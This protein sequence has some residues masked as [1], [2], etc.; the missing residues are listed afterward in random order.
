LLT[1]GTECLTGLWAEI[2]ALP[3][4]ASAAGGTDRRPGARRNLGV[5][6]G[7][8]GILY[9]SLRWC[10]A[11]GIALPESLP[12]LL[13]ELAGRAQPWGRGL[14]WR[15]VRGGDGIF[16]MAGWCNGS[17]GFV[18]LW[19]LAHRVLGEPSHLA[20]AEGAAWNAWEA[21]GRRGDLCCGLAGR[22][23]ALL[24]LDR[25]LHG[26]GAGG[27]GVWLDRARALAER[28]AEGIART[29]TPNS[30]YRGEIGVALL[31]VD[32]ERPEGAAMPFFEEEGWRGGEDPLPIPPPR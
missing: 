18:H 1:F 32:L 30:L 25:H 11:V 17:A 5:A 2:D 22:A 28:A 20:L 3:A 4:L 19:T 10:R 21:P 14:R 6:H 29:E 16:S 13:A 15:W 31:A 8:A 27:N 23:Y 24:N 26:T 12:A 7:W 9:A